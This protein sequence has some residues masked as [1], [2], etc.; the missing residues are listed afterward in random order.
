ILL[1]AFGAISIHNASLGFGMHYWTVPASLAHKKQLFYISS[2]FY[3]ILLIVGK[4]SILLVYLRIFPNRDFRR[5]VYALALILIFHG[6]IFCL[7]TIFQCLPVDSIWDRSMESKKCINTNAIVYS[8]GILSILEDF[9]ILV[10]PVR[11]T[12]QLNINRKKRFLILALFS[13]GFFA[14]ITSMV[15]MKYVVQ[16]SATFDA[17]WDNVDIVVWSAVE[18]FSAILCASLPALRPLFIAIVPNFIRKQRNVEGQGTEQST[19]QPQTRPKDAPGRPMGQHEM[20]PWN[21]Y[22][23]PDE[24]ENLGNGEIRVTTTID[25]RWESGT[26]LEGDS[27]Q[28]EEVGFQSKTFQAP[29]QAA[30]KA[31]LPVYSKD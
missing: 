27:Q 10:M 31:P 9:A 22:G 20:G 23:L 21:Q 30:P 8:S 13:I 7:L 26:W 11:Q 4:L 17:T 29:L 2:I 25:V 1:V 5:A 14:C 3:M 6:A 16:Y 18:Q 19:M 12:W 28:D 24:D 15:R